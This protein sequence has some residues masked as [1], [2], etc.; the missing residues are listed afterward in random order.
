MVSSEGTIPDSIRLCTIIKVPNL[1]LS[2]LDYI[3]ADY[4]SLKYIMYVTPVVL[5]YAK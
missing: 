3:I 1:P 5:L 4:L 2:L